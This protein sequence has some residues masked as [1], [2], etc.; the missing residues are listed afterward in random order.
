[1]DTKLKPATGPNHPGYVKNFMNYVCL[2]SQLPNLTVNAIGLF[3]DKGNLFLR[4]VIS[5]IIVL[6]SCIFT[7]V[8]IFV[9]TQSCKLIHIL[10]I[11][12]I[13]CFYF[14]ASWI[15]Y[16]HNG[17]C[18]YLELSQWLLPE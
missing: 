7:I 13:I 11:F 10:V 17:Y 1:M 6:F 3:I 14:R 5:L 12:I 4:I 2:F 9:D 8:F 15:L 18:S 16:R